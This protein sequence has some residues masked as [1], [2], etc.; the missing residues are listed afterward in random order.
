MPRSRSTIHVVL[1]AVL[2]SACQTV[3]APQ[4]AAPRFSPAACSTVAV[5]GRTVT[6]HLPPGRLGPLPMLVALHGLGGTGHGLEVDS[7]LDAI[8][9][10]DGA[11]IAYPDAL[12]GQW[13]QA[14]AVMG[15]TPDDAGFL[16][17][18]VNRLVAMGCADPQRVYAIGVSNGGG[19]AY[20][21][22]CEAADRVA[23][24]G[25]VSA[26]YL[27]SDRCARSRPVAAIAFH[28]TA[29]TRVPLGGV[30]YGTSVHPPVESW[31]A[32]WAVRNGCSTAPVHTVV[33]GARVLHWQG[34]P[35][36][37]DVLL[38]EVSGGTHGW[39]KSPVDASILSWE[40][41]RGRVR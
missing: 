2:A 5:P 15:S 21:L 14:P 30:T 18:L 35:Q 28:G 9:D 12:K 31:A 23:A 6:M 39:F 19:M 8:A 33:A 34:C 24:I 25:L 16:V 1:L 32:A 4:P 11:V 36:M 20:R 26:D 13:N 3:Q 37:A 17:Q 38:Y 41:F 10:R 27:G 40:F 7:G 22:A 29:D